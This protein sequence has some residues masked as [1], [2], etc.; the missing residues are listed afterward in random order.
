MFLTVSLT[1]Q[2]E[3]VNLLNDTFVLV[4]PLC[5]FYMRISFHFVK[6][7]VFFFQYSITTQKGSP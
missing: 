5:D 4:L 7:L 3:T 6:L 2:T 1:V